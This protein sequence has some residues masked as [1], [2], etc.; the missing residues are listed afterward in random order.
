V[1]EKVVKWGG[2][3]KKGRAEREG[4]RSKINQ[5][6]VGRYGKKEK[7]VGSCSAGKRQKNVSSKEKR[8]ILIQV[9]A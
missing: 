6:A 5:G 9:D 4:G 3:K 1:I 8:G 2:G 7:K